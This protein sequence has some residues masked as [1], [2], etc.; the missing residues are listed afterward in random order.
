MKRKTLILGGLALL[1]VATFWWLTSSPYKRPGAEIPVT[2]VGYTNDVTG[3]LTAHS[4]K[5]NGAHPQF[6]V[7]RIKN[8]TRHYFSCHIGPVFWED[9]QVDAHFSKSDFDLSAGDGAT[10]AVPVPDVPKAWRCGV[11]LW[12][13]LP[14][15]KLELMDIAQRCGLNISERNWCA[16]SPEIT[17]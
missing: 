1:V 3:V 15:W 11:V 12:P 17:R 4:R 14:R 6:A 8:P 5:T 7:F 9:G 10:F 2:L 13:R 16:V